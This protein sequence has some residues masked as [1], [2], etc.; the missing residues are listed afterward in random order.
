MQETKKLSNLYAN[1]CQQVHYGVI[2]NVWSCQENG[3]VI[4]FTSVKNSVFFFLPDI[5][6]DISGEIDLFALDII[7]A[8]ILSLTS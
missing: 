7:D 8:N 3:F 5:G 6:S 2:D 4:F 1:S